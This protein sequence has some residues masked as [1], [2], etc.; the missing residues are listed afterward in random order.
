MGPPAAVDLFEL[1]DATLIGDIRVGRNAG[2]PN[3]LFATVRFDRCSGAPAPTAADFGC[4]VE[5]CAGSGG[6][7]AGCTCTVM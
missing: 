4:T 3:G 6:P 5:A 2:F 7:I 1:P